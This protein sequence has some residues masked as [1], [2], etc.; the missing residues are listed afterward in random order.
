MITDQNLYLAPET[1][2]AWA[3]LAQRIAKAMKA[4]LKERNVAH[5]A[6][7]ETFAVGVAPNSHCS[8]IAVLGNPVDGFRFEISN[9]LMA[10]AKEYQDAPIVPTA[11]CNHEIDA[12]ASAWADKVREI[13]MEVC[14]FGLYLPKAVE[15]RYL[16]ADGD[17]SFRLLRAWDPV[18]SGYIVRIDTA[19]R[20]LTA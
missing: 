14:F 17:L 20:D 5:H 9:S 10:E 19:F 15:Q 2:E 6:I 3:D 12:M 8:K 18:R 1:A 11:L 16:F 13:S 4:A 7:S